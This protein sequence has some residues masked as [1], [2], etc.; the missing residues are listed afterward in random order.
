MSDVIALN[1]AL[2]GVLSTCTSALVTSVRDIRV[3]PGN[4]RSLAYA[5][6]KDEDAGVK[7]RG[8][9]RRVI[10]VSLYETREG[11][12]MI[13]LRAA[14]GVDRRPLIAD[15]IREIRKRSQ[16]QSGGAPLQRRVG[17]TAAVMPT[18]S[19]RASRRM[20]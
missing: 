8:R 14:L 17:P 7:R 11:P 16:Q 15:F 6:Q 3:P 1:L 10:V 5:P 9:R 13:C 20:Q 4:Y 19:D 12:I 2:H 18:H